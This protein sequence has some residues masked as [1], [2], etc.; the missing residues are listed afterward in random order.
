MSLVT[1]SARTVAVIPEGGSSA[2]LGT[3]PIA[4]AAPSQG[5]DPF[6]LDMSTSAVAANKV[7]V[8]ALPRLATAAGLGG[9]WPRQC[10]I[11]S[12]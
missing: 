4:F 2:V 5:E 6:L 1:S 12:A 10:G 7:K 11:E 3:N 9:R 8:H